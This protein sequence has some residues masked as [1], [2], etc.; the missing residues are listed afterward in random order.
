MDIIARRGGRLLYSPSDAT[1]TGYI[2]LRRVILCPSAQL[3]PYRGYI[4]RVRGRLYFTV[5]AG[6]DITCR[7]QISPEHREDLT[8]AIGVDITARHGG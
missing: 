2:R 5:T 1:A 7:R 4:D 3:Y 8:H 6:G